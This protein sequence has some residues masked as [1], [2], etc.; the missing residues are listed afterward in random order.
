MTWFNNLMRRVAR[1]VETQEVLGQEVEF[2][3]IGDARRNLTRALRLLQCRDQLDNEGLVELNARLAHARKNGV[4]VS[5][6]DSIT[7]ALNGCI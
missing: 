4:D 2:N 7:E 6:V 3:V 5:S 1:T